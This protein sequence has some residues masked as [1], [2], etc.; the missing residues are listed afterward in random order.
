MLLVA[1]ECILA[2]NFNWLETT[3]FI[4]PS[5]KKNQIIPLKDIREFCLII[6]I[7]SG[8]ITHI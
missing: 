2:D 6:W 7:F 8:Q 5:I 1:D 3:A 4:A